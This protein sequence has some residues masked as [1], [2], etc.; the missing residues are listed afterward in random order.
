MH[1]MTKITQAR[2]RGDAVYK[3]LIV[4]VSSQTEGGLSYRGD[5]RCTVASNEILKILLRRSSCPILFQARQT[6]IVSAQLTT[7]S[8]SVVFLRTMTYYFDI[9]ICET[10]I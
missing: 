9:I 7:R 6:K 4:W 3:L 5:T 8:V 2:R 10:T 1:R